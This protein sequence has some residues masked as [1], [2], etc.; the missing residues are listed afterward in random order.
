MKWRHFIVSRECICDNVFAHVCLYVCV[1]V[2]L[3][4]CCVCALTFESL[5]LETSILGFGFVFRILKPCV[6][7]GAVIIGPLRFLIEVVK[8]IPNQG[9]DCFVS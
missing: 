2:Y 5:D 3:S 6:G 1:S 9:L 8:A 7:S 4:D